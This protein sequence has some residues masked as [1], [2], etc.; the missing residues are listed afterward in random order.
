VLQSTGGRLMSRIRSLSGV[1]ATFAAMSLLSACSGGGG[2][3][4]PSGQ[5]NTTTVARTPEITSQSRFLPSATTGKLDNSDITYVA[6][7]PIVPAGTS[8]KIFPP[9]PPPSICREPLGTTPQSRGFNCYT[10]ALVR[11]GYNIPSRLDGAGQTIVIVDAFGSP[12]VRSDLHMF[13][14]VMGLPDPTLNIFHPTGSPPPLIP[15]KL[16]DT[17]GW[18]VET[19]L[20]VQWS[21]AIAPGAT[22]DLVIASTSSGNVLNL[23]QQFVVQH[24]L[25]NVMSLSFGAPEA[26]IRGLGNNIQLRQADTIYQA[27]A[28]AGI[29]VFVSSGDAG[30]TNG[31]GAVNAQFPASDP[32]VTSVGGTHLFLADSGAYESEDVWNDVDACPFGCTRGQDGVTGGAPSKIFAAPAYQQPFSGNPARTTSDV[33]YNASVYT[34][35]LVYLGFEPVPQFF[36][37]GGTSEGAP[38]WAAL[39]ALADQAAG[40]SLGQIN[41]KLYAIASNPGKYAADFHDITSGDN[42]FSGPGFSAKAGY[43]IPTGLGSPNATNLINDLIA[44]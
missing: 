35:I 10:P 28:N 9:F 16:H 11:T 23:A 1:I 30:A 18:A 40:H 13:D 17:T 31:L 43:D 19:S 39:T 32:L 29:T 38:Q 3:I 14:Q 27:A 12:T 26:A 5:V 4:P 8:P 15:T 6:N 22:I 37:V 42:N 24:H 20:D 7:P 2:S 36:F 44:P 34:G 33:G 21:H 25:G 41:L